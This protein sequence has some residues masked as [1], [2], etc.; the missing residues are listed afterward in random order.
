MPVARRQFAQFDSEPSSP[1]ANLVK[2]EGGKRGT[3]GERNDGRH[4]RL[5]ERAKALFYPIGAPRRGGLLV[6]ARALPPDFEALEAAEMMEIVL[7]VR[8]V[9]RVGRNL[10]QTDFAVENR[11]GGLVG[12]ARDRRTHRV[13]VRGTHATLPQ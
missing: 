4:E 13:A 10:L 9:D 11:A 5:C 7:R 3:A 1:L 12:A 6:L 8:H 2:S